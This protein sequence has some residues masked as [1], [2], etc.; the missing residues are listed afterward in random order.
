MVRQFHSLDPSRAS[1][2]GDTSHAG[3]IDGH[4]L[5]SGVRPTLGQAIKFAN[6]RLEVGRPLRGAAETLRGSTEDES[7][8]PS[9][10][11]FSLIPRPASILSVLL[12]IGLAR[13]AGVAGG[14]LTVEKGR[15][16]RASG[17]SHA[18]HSNIM[19]V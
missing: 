5:Y 19:V 16:S 6:I 2:P 1:F 4:T 3:Q 9:F 14:W 11:A 15:C 10:R 7:Y 12:A 13:K 18:A 17:E 8:H